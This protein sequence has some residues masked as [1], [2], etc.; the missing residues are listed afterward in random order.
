MLEL[1]R[2]FNAVKKGI[3]GKSLRGAAM[4]ARYVSLRRTFV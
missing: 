2:C 4:G 1:K 3:Y